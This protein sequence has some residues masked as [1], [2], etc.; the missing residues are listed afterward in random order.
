[1]AHLSHAVKV[2]DNWRNLKQYHNSPDNSPLVHLVVFGR[3]DQNL[4]AV[5]SLDKFSFQLEN[6]C[7]YS[8]EVFGDLFPCL[9]IRVDIISNPDANV[10]AVYLNRVGNLPPKIKNLSTQLQQ[11]Q[12]APSLILGLA[13]EFAIGRVDLPRASDSPFFLCT[14]E[15]LGLGDFVI[16]VTHWQSST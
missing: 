1:M 5:V 3:C 16:A 4:E 15:V 14:G 10:N 11:L 8:F 12:I 13:V 6:I 9:E 2:F 7:C